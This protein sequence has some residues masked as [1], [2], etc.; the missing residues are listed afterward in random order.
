MTPSILVNCTHGREDAERATL[1]FVIGNVSATADQ[2]TAVL[3]TCEGVGSARTGTPMTSS[4]PACPSCATC[5][6]RSST[7]GGEI[8]ACGTCTGPRGITDADLDPGAR[9]VTAAMVVEAMVGG[10][11]TLSFLNQSWLGAAPQARAGGGGNWEDRVGRDAQLAL[12]DAWLT[13]RLTAKSG[14][15]AL[16]VSGEAGVG[17]TALLEATNTGT[18]S[19][20]RAAATPWPPRATGSPSP[21]RAVGG[22]PWRRRW[23]SSSTI[24]TGPMTRRCELLGRRSSTRSRTTRSPS[25]ARTESDELAPRPPATAAAGAASP[26]PA[27][28]RGRT[29]SAAMTGALAE[30]ITAILAPAARPGDGRAVADRTEG[31]PFFI[32]EL[33]RR[34]GSRPAAWCRDGDRVRLA[35]GDDLPLPDT[36]RDA[37][38]LRASGLSGRPRRARRRRR[39]RHRVRRAHSVGGRARRLA[40]RTRRERPDCH[41]EAGRSAGSGTRS[42]RRRST[43]RC[44]GPAAAPCTWR[45]RP[46]GSR[47]PRR[48]LVARHLLAARDFE[49][50]RPALLA[51]AAG[52]RRAYAYRDA[53]RLLT[54]RAGDVAAGAGRAGPARGG[55]PAGSVRRTV[56]RPA[57]PRSPACANWS[58]INPPAHA[59]RCTAGSR[60]S[61]S[62]SATG[63]G[64]RRTGGRRR[65]RSPPAAGRRRPAAE[66]L[67]VAAHLR[68]AASFRAALDGARPRRGRRRRGGADRPGVPHRRPA[69][70]RPVPD[71]PRRRGST[72]VRAALDRAL[73]LGS[74]A[75]RRDLPAPRRLTRARR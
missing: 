40:G 37:V 75:G 74:H 4:S 9:I 30:L 14:P 6:R 16:F 56:R 46:A 54:D 53:A 25:S 33:T 70:Q 48:S 43:P 71:G 7:A 61:T 26:A 38:L 57:H 64:T 52:T 65:A 35:P 36:V 59:P 3:L 62:G 39:H 73:R 47:M 13:E 17:K 72:I 45:S 60:S 11:R 51:A 29:R 34:A 12:V 68:S 21:A 50:A 58:R 41:H 15:P 67:A 28:D 69:R 22:E 18:A 49:R 20:R 24:C 42:R 44:R 10:A 31:V 27:A 1:S 32:E 23:W 5:S 63:R 19:V 66:R 2:P 8:W 55:R